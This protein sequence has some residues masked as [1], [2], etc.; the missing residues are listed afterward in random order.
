MNILANTGN[1]TLRRR[2]LSAVREELLK[3]VEDKAQ[4]NS[5]PTRDKRRTKN[6]DTAPRIAVKYNR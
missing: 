5:Y 2:V 3:R 6:R 4:S 1:R